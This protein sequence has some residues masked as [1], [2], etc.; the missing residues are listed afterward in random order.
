[1]VWGIV[2]IDGVEPLVKVEGSLKSKKYLNI[3]RYCLKK[4]TALINTMVM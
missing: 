3:I 1:M 4:K 2:S